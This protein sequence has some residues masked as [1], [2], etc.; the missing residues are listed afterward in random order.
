MAKE[1]TRRI[2]IL[3]RTGS[4]KSN[5]GNT[6]LG[7]SKFQVNSSS[8]S[9]TKTC[10]VFTQNVCGRKVHLI[11]TPGLFDTDPESSDLSPEILKCIEKCAPG[12]HAFLLVL[13]VEK[14][15]KQEQ[16]VVDLILQYFSEEALKYTTVVFTH[17][18]Q[19][20]KG[21]TIKEWA[22]DNAALS[23]L[24]QKCGGR[25]HV[26]DNK[27]WNNSHDPYRNNQHQV[28]EL[29]KTIDQTVQKNE[30]TCYTNEMLKKATANKSF[31]VPLAGVS[32][33]IL[34]GALLGIPVMV[35]VILNPALGTV[36]GGRSTLTTGAVVG[37]AV[38]VGGAAYGGYRG[39]KLAEQAETPKE[40]AEA[41]WEEAK[42]LL[43]MLAC[44]Y[45]K[46]D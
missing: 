37:G 27:Y 26:F 36:L 29:L 4:G 32:T 19:L 23:K 15:T 41:V 35:M 25:C 44:L 28:R 1:E 16:D 6:I 46:F 21:V 10:Q 30:G 11:D 39:Y 3:G 13:K 24:I 43:L 5:M 17:G 18:D 12:P 45:K 14:F 33:G 2:V 38:A 8:N 31:L 20:D 34:L 22:K 42:A 7:E 40:A 9:G